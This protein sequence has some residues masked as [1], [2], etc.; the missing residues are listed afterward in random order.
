ML[1]K[2]NQK[3]IIKKHIKGKLRV[4]CTALRVI[5]RNMRTKLVIGTYDDNVNIW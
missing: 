5:E 2:V 4:R 1:Y 3:E